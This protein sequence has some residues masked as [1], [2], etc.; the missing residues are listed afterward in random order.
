MYYLDLGVKE[1]AKVVAGGKRVG[2]VGYFIEPTIFVN[3]EDQM[4]FAQ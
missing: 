3:V 4:K 1:G 2:N